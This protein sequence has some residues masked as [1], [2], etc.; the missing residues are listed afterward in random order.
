MR[1]ENDTRM[2]KITYTLYAFI[3]VSVL[4]F[5]AFFYFQPSVESTDS[6]IVD[7]DKMDT[8]PLDLQV[9]LEKTVMK[10]AEFLSEF[11]NTNSD[12]A[13]ALYEKYIDVI[14]A[15]GI[16]HEIQTFMPKCHGAGHPLGMLIYHKLGKVGPAL[17]TCQDGCNSGCMHGVL[18]EAFATDGPHEHSPATPVNL[19]HDILPALKS[20]I[21]TICSTEALTDMYNPGDCAHGVGHAVMYT[22]NYDILRAMEHCRLFDEY[23]MEYYC[24]TGAYMEYVNTHDP[25]DSKKQPFFYPCDTGEYPA[26][27]FRFKMVYIFRRHYAAN[28]EQGEIAEKCMALEGKY[29]LG[30]FHGIGNAHVGSIVRGQTSF[31]EICRYGTE[32]DQYMCIEGAVERMAKYHPEQ[33]VQKC[34]K[35]DGWR[36]ELCLEGANRMTAYDLDK[37]FKYY[38]Q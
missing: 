10:R 12:T 7:K 3:F 34:Q 1:P 17:Q 18:M 14:G 28:S 36:K 16:L 35:L 25:V 33:A 11:R 31:S 2:K 19:E 13:R 29:R 24:A 9:P 37:S 15:N 5:A 4:G 20:S 27:C 30:C 23:A 6:P 38:I 22:V 32:Q 21:P 26:A 8:D